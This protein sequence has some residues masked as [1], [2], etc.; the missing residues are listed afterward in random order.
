MNKP[1][2]HKELPSFETIE[3]LMSDP[4]LKTCVQKLI[5]EMNAGRELVSE[6]GTKKLKE[7]PVEFL[8]KMNC[9]TAEYLTKEYV[10]IHY[11]RTVLS[12][13]IRRFITLLIRECVSETFKHYQHLYQKQQLKI[14]KTKQS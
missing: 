8:V 12:A 10:E 1:I 11:K 3:Q 6:G 9:F 4:Y 2:K 7:S 13:S 5:D 14:T